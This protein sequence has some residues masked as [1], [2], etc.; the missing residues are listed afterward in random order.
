[1][2]KILLRFNR[3]TQVKYE[4]KLGN[5]SGILF[6]DT[7]RSDK[8]NVLLMIL[9]KALIL[10]LAI[11]GSIDCYMTGFGISYDAVL[12]A[13]AIAAI[14]IIYSF[15]NTNIVL[16]ALVYSVIIYYLSFLLEDRYETI[17]SG[18]TAIVN[19]SYDLIKEK[20]KFPDVD[21]FR[22]ILM[23]RTT[24]VPTVII[25]ASIIIGMML[26]IFICR[27]MN[28]LVVM[29]MTSLPLFAALFFGGIPSYRGFIMLTASWLLT[30]VVKF[31]DKFGH[32]RFKNKMTPT[33]KK[34]KIFYAQ[35]CD[36]FSIFQS[37]VLMLI[38]AGFTVM[39]PYTLFTGNA[40]DNLVP[41]SETKQ[42][43]DY[44]VRDTMIIAFSNYKNYKI[45]SYVGAGQL[46]FYGNVQPDFQ[47]DLQVTLVPY[48]T[49]RTYLRSFI[50][51]NY[52]YRGN[53]W[54]NISNKRYYNRKDANST[55]EAIADSGVTAKARIYNVALENSPAYMP[56]YT[57]IDENDEFAYAQDDIISSSLGVSQTSEVTYHPLVG[58]LADS[59]TNEYITDEYKSY[60][61][62]NYLQ[63][64]KQ[65]K[66]KLSSLCS[67][68]GFN[69]DDENLEKKI[70]DFFQNN[71]E[72]DLESGRLPWN[73]DFVEY[74]LFENKRGV[75][76]HFASATTLIYRSL[77]IPAR[78][79]E[80]YAMDYPIIMQGTPVEGENVSDWLMGAVPL[81]SSVMQF[82]LSDYNAHAWVEIYKDGVGWV[83]VDTT[84]YV[85]E[86]SVK[87]ETTQKSMGEEIL[88]Y[89]QELRLMRIEYGSNLEFASAIVYYIM[90]MAVFLLIAA[91]VIYI[92]IRPL[93]M[94]GVRN[95]IA[96]K[97]DKIKAV[98]LMYSYASNIAV[99][100]KVMEKSGYYRDFANALV[101]IGMSEERAVLLFK[102]TEKAIYSKNGITDEEYKLLKNCY[103][104][105][106]KLILLHASPIKRLFALIKIIK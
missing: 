57:D 73:T 104:E 83:T 94:I 2:K 76:A 48:T 71:Y 96:F 30:A 102:I 78:Y 25:I 61:Y 58:E 20:Y 60:V 72:Y 84:P 53:L 23:D 6:L 34:G 38:I 85:E 55:A 16:T 52:T 10:F 91:A 80:G 103:N 50:G 26:A 27:F 101:G 22:E 97:G 82:D 12:I 21:G 42:D 51:S 19:M 88:D 106:V 14:A 15:A 98:R 43:I 70:S 100:C 9:I 45:T 95:L 56:Y 47:T 49:E 17:S 46:G 28:V 93:M 4:E 69:A 74:F 87:E 11:M 89:F 59:L 62:S 90:R 39:V 68:E 66:I 24:T 64:P 63:I 1:M 7:P 92:L 41:Q 3:R 99:Y 35:L 77:G 5:E 40:F 54:T 37:L 44:A 105:S 18:I 33:Y 86:D 75:C 81:S 8:Q 29:V 36:G 65:L 13:S 79:V 31:S 67:G 32:I